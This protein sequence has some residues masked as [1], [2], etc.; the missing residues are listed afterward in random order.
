M[1]LDATGRVDVSHRLKFMT[2]WLADGATFTTNKRRL[3]DF[4]LA[5]TC[6]HW[7]RR[8]QGAMEQE[9]WSAWKKRYH[10]RMADLYPDV[11]ILAK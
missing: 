2:V 8:V 6:L 9:I 11:L 7:L 1:S 10:R 5:G 3:S 4:V